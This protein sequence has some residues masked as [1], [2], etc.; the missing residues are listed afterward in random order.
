MRVES[1]WTVPQTGE[2][3]GASLSWFYS[4]ITIGK[5]P[6]KQREKAS[7]H[8]TARTDME[9]TYKSVFNKDFGHLDDRIFLQSL[10]STKT[11]YHAISYKK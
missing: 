9:E 8:W 4:L 11:S 10:Q 2:G 3:L 7:N 6:T 1:I 5:H